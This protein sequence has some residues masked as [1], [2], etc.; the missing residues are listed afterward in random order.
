MAELTV[1]GKAYRT[2]SDKSGSDLKVLC[3]ICKE[4]YEPITIP[5]YEAFQNKV[6]ER[7]RRVILHCRALY[8]AG[9]PI[10]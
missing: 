6:C 8:E 1:D 2:C 10:D 4:E 9:A 5:Q 7:C 3:I